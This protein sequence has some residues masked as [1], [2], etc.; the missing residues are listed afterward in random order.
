MSGRPIRPV[1]SINQLGGDRPE[2]MMARRWRLESWDVKKQCWVEEA[3]WHDGA[4]IMGRPRFERAMKEAQDL[5]NSGTGARVLDLL[6][7]TAHGVLR[8]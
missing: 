2:K 7:G 6:T 8:Q 3:T 5:V 4:S 1:R